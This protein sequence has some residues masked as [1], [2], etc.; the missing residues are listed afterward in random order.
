MRDLPAGKRVGLLLAFASLGACDGSARAARSATADAPPPDTRVLQTPEPGHLYHGVLPAGTTEPDSDISAATL[1]AYEH[2]VTLKYLHEHP[3]ELQAFIDFDGVQQYKL[4]KQIMD[5]FGEGALPLEAVATTE[6]KYAEVKDKFMVKSCK[7]KMC[8]EQRVGVTW[9]KLDFVS[10]AKR[11]GDIGSLIVPS[12][13]EPLRHTH[14][15]FRAMTERIDMDDNQMG[16]Q[17]EV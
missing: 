16:F 14:S 3:D 4:A 5:T 11:A 15:T 2:T 6:R 9:S 8:S 12:Y 10:L 7:S 13:F 17:R 1:D